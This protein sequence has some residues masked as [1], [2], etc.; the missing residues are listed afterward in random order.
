[1]VITEET[2][3]RLRIATAA[4][5][6]DAARELGRLLCML[7]TDSP[8]DAM[9]DD[10]LAT[11]PEEP[12]LRAALRAR[13]DDQLAAVLLAGRLVQQIAFWQIDDDHAMAHGEDDDTLARR[14]DEA[15][16]L[17]AS[18]LK[19][20]PGNAAARAGVATLNARADDTGAL[21]EE[22]PFS[23]YELIMEAGSG[24]FS[25][26]EHVVA[27]DP[28]EVRWACS[29]LVA[30]MVAQTVE[31]PFG[32]DLDLFTY[33]NGRLGSVVHLGRHFHA[34]GTLDWDAVEIPPLTGDPLPVGHR[35]G[36]GH[37]GYFCD[38]G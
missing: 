9:D 10:F 4:G 20:D 22:P 36:I 24:S 29:W 17:Y 16:A 25:H 37:Y 14:H 5:D 30:P 33:S 35:V 15:H 19:T 11:W 32:V 28:D 34:D 6:P 26:S 2:I 12:L 38:W 18:V 8:V 27:T 21:E 31:P 3:T 13:P 1:M 23:Y 7:R